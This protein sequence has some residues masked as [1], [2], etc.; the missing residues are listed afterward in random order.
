MIW[1][2]KASPA[3]PSPGWATPPRWSTVSTPT[4]T[5]GNYLV[6][7]RAVDRAGNLSTLASQPFAFETAA[8][9]TQLAAVGVIVAGNGGYL[10]LLAWLLQRERVRAF[11]ARYRAAMEMG[12]GALFAAFGLR[13]VLHELVGWL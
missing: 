10:A 3:I 8:P 1:S 2:V 12:F 7:A 5:A 9:A 13:L 11:Y 6:Q 4:W